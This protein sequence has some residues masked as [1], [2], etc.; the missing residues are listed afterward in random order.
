MLFTALLFAAQALALP[1]LTE[2]DLSRCQD[3]EGLERRSP[4]NLFKA[5]ML[6]AAALAP[7]NQVQAF[8]H[9]A[10]AKFYYPHLF[11]EK[12]PAHTVDLSMG[13]GNK[14]AA[15]P[16]KAEKNPF[17]TT[18]PLD[19]VKERAY[20]R[21]TKLVK[22]GITKQEAVKQTLAEEPRLDIDMK[23]RVHDYL[24]SFI[25]LEQQQTLK[26]IAMLKAMKAQGIPLKPTVKPGNVF[27][28]LDD[29]FA[30][31]NK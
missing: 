28:G 20:G 1:V 2:A 18:E 8:E 25:I 3:R 11:N 4:M 15:P 23:D 10:A 29:Q 13:V 21:Y 26:E 7:P 24:W 16:M 31:F 6:A 12:R 14:A 17:Y 19:T 9:N 30:E 5:C 22:S 27:A